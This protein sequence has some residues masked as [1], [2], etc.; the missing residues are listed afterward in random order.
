MIKKELKLNRGFT[1]LE[2][3][4][5]VS[6]F[7]LIIMISGSLYTISQRSYTSSENKMELVQNGRVAFDR[8]SRELRQSV[9]IATP[10]ASSSSE[11]E[12]E[13]LF[14][15]GHD[16]NEITYVYYYLSGSNLRRAKI[17]YYFNEEP[18]IYVRYNSR[19]EDSDLPENVVLEDRVVGEYFKN[20]EFW[21]E[22]GLVYASTTLANRDEEFK[23]KTNIFSRN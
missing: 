18:D 13:I 12:T 5:A 16:S 21:G 17:A 19:N 6:I 2:I 10:L 1:L 8:L 9:E 11:T 22:Y 7:V 23:I 3:V 15:D 20:I 4:V 14:Q